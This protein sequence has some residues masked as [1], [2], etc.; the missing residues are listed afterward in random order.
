MRNLST[1]LAWRKSY[2]FSFFSVV[3][4]VFWYN[5]LNTTYSNKESSKKVSSKS[6]RK[7]EEDEDDD[8][9]ENTSEGDDSSV[10]NIP[11]KPTRTT[12][13]RSNKNVATTKINAQLAA[14]N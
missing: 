5:L 11:P 9:N 1:H 13:S 7:T 10:K 12:S 3:W 4:I 6:K 2:F 14:E 8:E